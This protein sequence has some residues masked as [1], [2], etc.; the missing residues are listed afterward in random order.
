MTEEASGR[1]QWPERL[2]VETTASYQEHLPWA[3]A[4]ATEIALRVAGCH[5][6]IRDATS[7]AL[8]LEG[9][10]GSQVRYSVLRSLYFADRHSL[11]HADTSRRVSVSP[12]T[13]TRVIDG[14]EADGLVVRVTDPSDRR[15]TLI[16][17]TPSGEAI[18]EKLV[19]V[20]AR[21][22]RELLDQ[23]SEDEKRS[24]LDMLRRIQMR[25]E[26]LGSPRSLGALAGTDH[27][28]QVLE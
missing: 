9:Y 13:L 24:L 15:V 8:S 2:Y 4:A 19:P 14:M 28:L 27:N 7:R 17:L 3:D 23:F 16:R 5:N 20:V 1:K 21:L 25:A 6:A 10:A 18:S 26:Q 11:S 12:G 22:R